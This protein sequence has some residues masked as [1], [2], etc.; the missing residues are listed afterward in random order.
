MQTDGLVA[1]LGVQL[2]QRGLSEEE[3]SELLEKSFGW[4]GQVYAP[5]LRLASAQTSCAMKQDGW[6]IVT[7]F[8]RRPACAV[9]LAENT[10]QGGSCAGAT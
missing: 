4:R 2:T 5:Q 3:A 1:M 8:H 7:C 10:S 9:L 6:L